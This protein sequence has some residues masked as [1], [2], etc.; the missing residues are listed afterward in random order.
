MK[1]RRA[2]FCP[3]ALFLCFSGGL[4]FVSCPG[5][6]PALR[7]GYYSAEAAGFD[8][9]GWKEFVTISV[10]GGRIMAVEYNAK[11]PS[12][13]IKSWDMDYMRVMNA[14]DGT[15][16]NEYTRIY[17]ERLIAG[18][19]VSGVDA[20]S[21]ATNSHGSFKRLAGKAIENSRA[22]DTSVSIIPLTGASGGA[23]P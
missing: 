19:D 20:L 7:D 10:N 9:H 15:Y 17:A 13:F 8:D 21:G 16:P 22:G 6:A 3:V 23:G 1:T 2:F 4:F 5:R 14:Q 18:Q 11:N 12:G